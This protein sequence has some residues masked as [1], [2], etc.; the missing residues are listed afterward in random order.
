VLQTNIVDIRACVAAG[1]VYKVAYVPV[2]AV[3]C[4]CE[5]LYDCAILYS[6]HKK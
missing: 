3:P 5:Y 6:Y 1:V 4:T 2:D